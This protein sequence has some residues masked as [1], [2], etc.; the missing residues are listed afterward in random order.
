[1]FFI[2]RQLSWLLYSQSS[3]PQSVIFSIYRQLTDVS[4][5]YFLY[6]LLLIYCAYTSCINVVRSLLLLRILCQAAFS[7]WSN[8]HKILEEWCSQISF[9][10][11]CLM[12]RDFVKVTVVK[13]TFFMTNVIIIVLVYI[14]YAFCMHY[15]SN[16]VV[17]L[18]KPC[19]ANTLPYTYY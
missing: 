9:K 5:I 8:L 7:G 6:I 1:M 19:N 17:T 10:W 16:Y 4:Y 18:S 11:L 13:L 12:F 15:H 3:S 2:Y 14:L